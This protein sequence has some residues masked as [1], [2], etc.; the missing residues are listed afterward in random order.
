MVNVTIE[1]GLVHRPYCLT[2]GCFKTPTLTY[3]LEGGDKQ[4][5]FAVHTPVCMCTRTIINDELVVYQLTN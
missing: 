5:S 4:F 1:V 3:K 2:S